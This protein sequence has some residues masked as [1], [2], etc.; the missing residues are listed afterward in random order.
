MTSAP[1]PTR[2]DI[3]FSPKVAETGATPRIAPRIVSPK[4]PPRPKLCAQ[5]GP[6]SM[7]E[8]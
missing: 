1:A 8:A 2:A 5:P 4:S 7:V 3:T 6:A